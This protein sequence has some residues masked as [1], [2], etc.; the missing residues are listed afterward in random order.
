VC[1]VGLFDD[2]PLPSISRNGSKSGFGHALPPALEL[3]IFFKINGHHSA[4]DW[5]AE[6]EIQ[7]RPVRLFFLQPKT[8][9]KRLPN[10]TMARQNL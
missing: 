2:A 8:E 1:V 6:Q 10:S 4:A 3:A 7:P 5:C 9:S